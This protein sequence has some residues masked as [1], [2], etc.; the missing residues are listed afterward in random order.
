MI[1][2]QLQG[3]HAEDRRQQRRGRRDIEHIVRLGP[4]ELIALGR[5]GDD[6]AIARLDLLDLADHLV[7]HSILHG[8][9]H[10]R[11][12]LVNQGNRPVLHLA[13]RV[14]LRVDVADLL[15]LERALQ[16]GRVCLPP[17]D[18][19][20][21]SGIREISRD[22]LDLLFPSQYGIQ[23]CGYVHERRDDPL[24]GL[25]PQFVFHF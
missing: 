10:H 8:N 5:H 9:R 3:D 6:N 20:E 19:E 25:R 23:L 18:E 15:E 17:A 12:A 7:I 11:H 4:D 1:G 22:L 16:C 14:A 2:Q 21:P 13:G 24:F